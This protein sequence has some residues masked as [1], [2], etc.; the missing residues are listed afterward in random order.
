MSERC[1]LTSRREG[2]GVERDCFFKDVATTEIDTLSLARQ[3]PARG[4]RSGFVQW[5]VF[6]LTWLARNLSR[7]EA[8]W[9]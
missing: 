8:L 9:P 7:V 6:G 2:C 3:L 1:V 5:Q 4:H